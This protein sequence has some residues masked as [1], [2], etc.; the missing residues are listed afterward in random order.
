MLSYLYVVDLMCLWWWKGYLE[1]VEHRIVG[2]SLWLW[3]GLR[4]SI[5]CTPMIA[6]VVVLMVVQWLMLMMV[7]PRMM[8][9]IDQLLED[10]G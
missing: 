4:M 10:E 2:I 8:R 1:D 7:L 6:V 3:A 9:R 5:W